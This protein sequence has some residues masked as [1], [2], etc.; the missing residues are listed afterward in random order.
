MIVPVGNASFFRRG[1]EVV[2]SRRAFVVYRVE[3]LE[4][5]VWRSWWGSRLVGWV[6]FN[7]DWWWS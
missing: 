6:L 5:H 4:L 2:M 7:W 1:E 3:P